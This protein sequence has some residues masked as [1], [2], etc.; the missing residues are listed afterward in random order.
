MQDNLNNAIMSKWRVAFEKMEVRN[1][2]KA[3]NNQSKDER[4]V[5]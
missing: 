3:R 5:F 2:K 1:G 4:H